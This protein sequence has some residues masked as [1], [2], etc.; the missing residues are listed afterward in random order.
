MI[1]T[2]FYALPTALPADDP[3]VISLR[4]VLENVAKKAGGKILDFQVVERD[5]TID[6]DEIAYPAVFDFVTKM[7]DIFNLAQGF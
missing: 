2:I 5:V 4:T 1:M 3:I 6:C 7:A